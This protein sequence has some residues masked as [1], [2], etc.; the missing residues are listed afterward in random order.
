MSYFRMARSHDA[1]RLN[2][3]AVLQAHLE[4]EDSTTV[5]ELADEF[6]VS[7]RT[8]QRDL[9]LLRDRGL[10][11]EAERGRGG[12]V[13]LR[14]AWSTGRLHLSYAEAVDLLVSLS[15]AEQMRSPLLMAHLESVRRKLMASFSA[16]MRK[17]VRRLKSRIL[18]GPSVSP[19]VLLGV[20]ASSKPPNHQPVRAVTEALHQ[21]FIARQALQIRY[22]SEN[23]TRTR[24]VIEPHYLMLCYPLWYVAAW[25]RLRDDVRTFRCDRIERALRLEDDFVLRPRTQFR[26]AFHD[27]PL[28]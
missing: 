1:I 15:V 8:I 16:P 25:D 23:G 7:R 5:A 21:A 14:Q 26:S 11:I 4:S 22:R 20:S 6:H 18:V 10:P 3:L 2:R 24:R 28:R 19:K 27:I 9:D 13:R 17:K 12:G